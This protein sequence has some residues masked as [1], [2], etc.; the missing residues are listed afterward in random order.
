MIFGFAAARWIG[1][2]IDFCEN[3][4]FDTTNLPRLHVSHNRGEG[5][6][7]KIRPPTPL[8]DPEW[9]GYE[10]IRIGNEM[11]HLSQDAGYCVHDIRLRYP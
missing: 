9:L 10:E 7:R 5:G 4:S 6:G 2:D 3:N 1:E 8:H 11:T